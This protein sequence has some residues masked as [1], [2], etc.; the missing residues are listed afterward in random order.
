[1]K[2]G[3]YDS[4]IITI[5]LAC[6]CSS[7]SSQFATDES[8]GKAA[9]GVAYVVTP[10][11]FKNPAGPGEGAG[12]T[13]DPFRFQVTGSAGAWVEVVFALPDSFVAD[14]AS[15][16]LPLT[17]WTYRI[18]FGEGNEWSWWVDSDTL[19][20]PISS[21]GATVLSFGAMMDVPVAASYSP[22]RAVVSI[23]F[24]GKETTATRTVK[25][26]A[27]PDSFYPRHPGDR[28]QYDD[29]AGVA[30]EENRIL[31]DSLG[32]D[33]TIYLETSLFGKLAYHF[34]TLEIRGNTWGGPLYSNLLYKLNA[35]SG[36][37]WTVK[38][39]SLAVLRATIA[40]VYPEAVL[41]SSPVLVKKVEYSDS[42]TGVVVATEY[43]AGDVG[44]VRQ[45]YG[46]AIVRA[47]RGAIIDGTQRGELVS[48]DGGGDRMVP[49]ATTLDQNYPNP[50][51]PTTTISY[52]LP[53]QGFVTLKVFNVLGQEV[54]TLVNE[55][56]SPGNKSVS[57]DGSG[58]PSGVYFYRLQAGSYSATKML[59]IVK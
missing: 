29:G 55:A 17:H 24:A 54:A 39:D 52:T 2:H 38:R 47:I 7:A 5:L 11:G 46:G 18:A 14:G 45:E 16:S 28:W 43:L 30:I 42:A 20:V 49:D 35:D 56:E 44:L 22:Y 53:A 41:G 15:G 12:V 26:S 8:W 10:A 13:V 4:L 3:I 25:L 21:S 9:Q 58:L 36:A 48:V 37:G 59:M 57:F 40:D 6:V 23:T 50:F 33:D 32:L 19:I 1:M 34:P 31:S 27:Y 51:N